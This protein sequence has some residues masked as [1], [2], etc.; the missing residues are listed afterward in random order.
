[1]GQ[2]VNP[3]GLRLGV[4]QT[5]CSKWFDQ[6][7][8]AFILH[9]DLQIRQ[10]LQT[11]LKG[12]DL[13]VDPITIKRSAACIYINMKLFYAAEHGRQK[14][15]LHQKQLQDLLS[16]WTGKRVVLNL[17]FADDYTQSARLLASYIAY[18]L[19]KRTPFKEILR[20]CLQQCKLESNIKGV[21]FRCSGRL[22]G[23]EMARSEWV[24]DGQVPLHTLKEQIDYGTATA[25]TI[26]GVCGVKVWICRQE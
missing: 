10:Y 13:L 2:K 1:M 7:N 24:K 21:R 9:E 26:Y 18:R 4:N 20:R 25:N 6:A 3:I 8:Y 22:D 23:A 14:P 11:I 15:V 16:K 19:E 17:Q 12:M 5:W